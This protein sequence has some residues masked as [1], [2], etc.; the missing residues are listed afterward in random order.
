[1]FAIASKASSSG[2]TRPRMSP[3]SFHRSCQDRRKTRMVSP[4]PSGLSRATGATAER[5][6]NSKPNDRPPWPSVQAYKRTAAA[7]VPA[8]GPRPATFPVEGF[9]SR[10]NGVGGRSWGGEV[11]AVFESAQYHPKLRASKKTVNTFPAPLSLPPLFTFPKSRIVG[12]AFLAA[13]FENLFFFT[14]VPSAVQINVA[15]HPLPENP[16]PEHCVPCATFP[17]RC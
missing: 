5:R 17:G 16:C 15:L 7:V 4:E 10:R 2:S 3:A 13:V 1:M 11:S 9:H 12:V 8:D 14:S 6:P